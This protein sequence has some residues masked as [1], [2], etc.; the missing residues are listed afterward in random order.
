[1]TRVAIVTGGAQ[2]IGEGISRQLAED[3]SPSPSPT[4]TRNRR[5]RSPLKSEAKGITSTW[6]PTKT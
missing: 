5:I 4:S 3:G 2:G 6:L 1:M